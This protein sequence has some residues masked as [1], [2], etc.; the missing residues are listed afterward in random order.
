MTAVADEHRGAVGGRPAFDAA[1][2]AF[3]EE[4]GT[5]GPVAV[6]G[7]RT[8]FDL[9]GPL[10]EGTRVV[11]APTGIVAHDPSEMTVTVRAGTTVEMACL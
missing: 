8:R 9:G 5:S 1:V 10:A 4:V 6:A 11:M 2:T 3:A 7:G